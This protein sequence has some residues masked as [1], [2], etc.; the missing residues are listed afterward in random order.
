MQASITSFANPQPT[1][2]EFVNK[3]SRVLA[4]NTSLTILHQ[5]LDPSRI[6]DLP[7]RTSL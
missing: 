7:S 5:G 4:S 1:H 3:K 2:Y 6:R